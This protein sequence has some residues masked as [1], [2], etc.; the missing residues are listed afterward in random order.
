MIKVYLDIPGEFLHAAQLDAV[1]RVGESILLFPQ[2][3][4]SEVREVVRVEHRLFEDG[5]GYGYQEVR[6][7]LSENYRSETMVADSDSLSLLRSA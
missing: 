2:D 6:V 1:P 3:K 4:S 7:R 5:D